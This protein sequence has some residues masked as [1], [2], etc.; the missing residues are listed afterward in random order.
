MH[1]QKVAK[2][3]Q[4]AL[5][6]VIFSPSVSKASLRRLFLTYLILPQTYAIK[7]TGKPNTAL[8]SNSMIVIIQ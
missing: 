2:I 6:F 5:V 8:E 4:N 7:I 3:K 1:L